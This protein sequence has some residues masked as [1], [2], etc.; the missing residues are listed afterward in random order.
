MC[1]IPQSS[2]EQWTFT[3]RWI[4]TVYWH[5]LLNNIQDFFINMKQSP[6]CQLSN[7][8]VRW[9]NIDAGLHHNTVAVSGSN[10]AER[11]RGVH[12]ELCSRGSWFLDFPFPTI[13]FRL[14]KV[15]AKT[16]DFFLNTVLSTGTY[17]GILVLSFDRS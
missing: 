11:E 14:E 9:R 15:R 4:G 5:F 17:F 6:V 8:Y 1:S 16:L 2:S 12:C 13:E 3:Y 7:V 10:P